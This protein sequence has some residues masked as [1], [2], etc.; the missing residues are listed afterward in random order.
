MECNFNMNLLDFEQNK[1]VR[2]FVKID[3]GRSMIP[4]IKKPACIGKKTATAIDHI[5]INSAITVKFKTGITRS[6]TSDHFPIFF[7]TGYNIHIKEARK[8][9][10]IR[11][12]F[13][14]IS[15]EIFRHKLLTVSWDSI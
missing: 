1:K 4:I 13:S 6:D 8:R 2:T 7:V 3:F 11:R 12:N 15:V 5:F 10:I 9:Y 14:N